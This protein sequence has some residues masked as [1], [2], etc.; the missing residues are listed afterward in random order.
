MTTP[1]LGITEIREADPLAHI[2]VNTALRQ[3]EAHSKRIIQDISLSA[4]PG[5]PA[6]SS[7][8]YVVAS[9]TGAW[10]GL[11]G[12]I[13]VFISGAWYSFGVPDEGE[14]WFDLDSASWVQWSGAAWV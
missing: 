13:V 5:S 1:L 12:H 11:D 4:P 9:G 14:R 2:K 10:A 8:Y 6:E 3:L 7:V